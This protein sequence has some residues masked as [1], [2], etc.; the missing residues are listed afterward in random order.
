MRCLL[1]ACSIEPA[2]DLAI[3]HRGSGQ[4]PP[5]AIPDQA[6]RPRLAERSERRPELGTEELRLLPGGEVTALIDLVKVDQVSVGAPRPCLRGSVDLLRKYRDGHRE[7]YL[8]G[9][10]R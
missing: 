5:Q 4:A 8:R 3:T 1:P 9:L 10:L 2:C 7:R 6:G